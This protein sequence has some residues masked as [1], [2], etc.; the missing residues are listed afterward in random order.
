MKRRLSTAFHPQTD[1]Q[2]ERQ[3]QTLEHYLRCYVNFEQDDWARWLPLAQFTY[4]DS[5]HSSTGKS[6]SELLMGERFDL[7]IDIAA[8]EPEGLAPDA[9]NRAASMKEMREKLEEHLKDAFETQKKYYD[10]KHKPITFS[11]GDRVTLRTKNINLAR[12]CR[13]LAERQIGPFTIIDAWGK[14]A[15]KLELP[16]QFHDIHPVF[17][18]S[19]LELWRP[20]PGEEPSRP[21]PVVIQ[22]EKEWTIESILAERTIRRQ[23]QYLVKWLGYPDT[24]NSWNPLAFWKIQ[25]PLRSSKLAKFESEC[26]SIHFL[27]Q[28]QANVFTPIVVTIPHPFFSHWVL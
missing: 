24:E 22:G 3:N 27:S 17:H 11:V 6:P 20:R 13:K 2:T 19:L 15:Y 8:P 1:G 4:N 21:D 10:K 12:P 7:K 9:F 18:V 16:R 28:N 5:K 26:H 14:Q 25:P 23:T